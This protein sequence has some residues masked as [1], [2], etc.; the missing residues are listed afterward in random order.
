M[1]WKRIVRA[2]AW[3]LLFGI[4]LLQL[5]ASLV[6][7]PYLPLRADHY[8]LQYADSSGRG[9]EGLKDVQVLVR[10]D[11]FTPI[12]LIWTSFISIEALLVLWITAPREREG[13][14]SSPG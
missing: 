9:V 2:G 5:A 4:T 10:H 7:E 8:R 6:S 13:R 1:R 14:T 12:P 3:L 11:V